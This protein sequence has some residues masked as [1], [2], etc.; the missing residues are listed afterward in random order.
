MKPFK[1]KNRW[2][3]Q[4]TMFQQYIYM[5]MLLFAIPFLIISTIW[6]QTSK[7]GL[8]KQISQSMT[9]S[10]E[11]VQ[12]SLT[13]Q[14]DNLVKLSKQMPSDNRITPFML[15][16]DYYAKEGID[17]LKRYSLNSPLIEDVFLNFDNKPDIL[18]SSFGK[19]DIDA[20]SKNK[21]ANYK[22]SKE[23][24]SDQLKSSTIDL[25]LI[26]KK[27]D[28]LSKTE[29]LLFTVPLTDIS[30]IRYG[31]VSYTLRMKGMEK[32]LNAPAKDS[33]DSILI[34]DKNKQLILSS[35]DNYVIN[36][37]PIHY[38]NLLSKTTNKLKENG[39]TYLFVDSK[40]ETYQLTYLAVTDL[41]VAI[42]QLSTV[43]YTTIVIVIILFSLGMASIIYAG[44]KQYRP[45]RK[46]ENLLQEKAMN[47]REQNKTTSLEDQL[48]MVFED[49]Q[50]LLENIKYQTPFAR[51][52]VLTRLLS[53][54]LT[55]VEEL[56]LLLESVGVDFYH[57]SYFVMVVNTESDYEDVTDNLETLLK[58]RYNDFF[59]FNSVFYSVD[60]LSVTAVA[61]IVS[62][63]ENLVAIDAKRVI[64][65]FYD[66]ITEHIMPKV[67]IGVGELVLTPDKL[68]RSYIEALTALEYQK[69]NLTASSISY[70]LDI[71]S[72]ENTTEFSYP[73]EEQLKLIQSLNAGDYQVAK[74]TIDNMVE[75]GLHKQRS[76]SGVKMY[77]YY[78]LNTVVKSGVELCGVDFYKTGEKY[79]LFNSLQ[80]LHISLLYLA[81]IIC[82]KVREQPKDSK[83]KE[84][85]FA[86]INQF[87]CSPELSLES[88]SEEFDLSISY[89]SR[90]IKKESGETFSKYVQHLR[91]EKVKDQLINTEKPIKD[92]IQECGYYDASNYTRKFK[93]LVGVTPG[94]FR[95]M[96]RK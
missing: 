40:N 41:K 65:Q 31:S 36:D 56:D 32:E 15:E 30:G 47:A 46:I 57:G 34:F 27:D 7:N 76:V 11:R 52:Q 61:I 71:Q 22:W 74:E 63:E 35:N 43:H 88:L 82:Q 85:I 38:I 53:G 39:T 84:D 73:T 42:S 62:L 59:Q 69:T 44:Q 51:D 21:Y 4:K 19:I 55:N 37:N 66:D 18:Y 48:L 1:L 72:G 5:Y 96:E 8:E 23:L 25:Q 60:I 29:M 79:G 77:G 13:S 92:I 9:N 16:H 64:N 12:G 24:L 83:L 50:K 67:T 94:Q 17:E 86:Y 10:L 3:R 90:F 93:A 28:D 2:F 45:I 54:H 26:P 14:L 49:S 78:L 33:D 6:Y 68:N 58:D 87:Y 81:D 75:I 80:E 20:L 95:K 70:F 91:L 89:L